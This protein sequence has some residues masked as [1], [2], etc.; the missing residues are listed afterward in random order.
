[1]LREVLELL[2]PGAGMTVIDGTVGGGGHAEA[3]LDA[4]GPDGRLFGVDRDPIAL[5][6]AR[7]RL[8][9]FGDAF[10]PVRGDHTDLRGLLE[11]NGVFAVDAIL[12][13]LGVSS[14]QLDDPERGF[15]FRTDGPLDMRMDPS[16]TR[17]AAMIVAEASEQELTRILRELG[18]E[19]RAGAIARRIVGS[20]ELGAL[21]RT[22]EL[23]QLVE[24]T[25]GARAKRFRI[26][27]A[28]RTFQAL[29]IAVNGE[30][31]R[32]EDTIRSA[33]SLLKRRGRLAVLSYHSLE[34]RP[35]KVALRSLANR[36]VCPPRLP[37]CA[38]G[39]ENFVRVLTTRPLRPSPAEVE[40][41][42]RA[43]S[44]KLRAAERL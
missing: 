34:D 36:C 28:T 12:L 18:E 35:V 41:N 24:S 6:L 40:D 43:R 14:M 7:E 15:S 44:A 39:R 5:D 30:V 26:H 22:A 9:R 29:R 27:P 31:E 25:L 1:M 42:P 17:T 3:L 32:L 11:Q 13:D 19:R 23:A 38:C 2:S 37:V 10:V 33:V 16:Q 4:I 21:T 20:R 8:A